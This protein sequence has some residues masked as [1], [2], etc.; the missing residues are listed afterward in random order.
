VIDANFSPHVDRL[1]TC[2]ITWLVGNL[3]A[4]SVR[5]GMERCGHRPVLSSVSRHYYFDTSR[6]RLDAFATA[7][8]LYRLTP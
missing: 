5:D 6:L 8:T 2:Q 4:D 1:D 3:T 7:V